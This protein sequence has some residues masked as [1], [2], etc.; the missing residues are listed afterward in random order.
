MRALGLLTASFALLAGLPWA[1]HASALPDPTRPADAPVVRAG[2]APAPGGP[3]LQSTLVSAARRTAVID[4]RTVAVG[5]R[6]HGGTVVDI[7]PYEVRIRKN[8]RDVSL[9]LAPRLAREKG[10]VE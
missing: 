2:G 4:G 5:D 6:V 1:A 9:R 7:Q 8:G 3:V 10:R